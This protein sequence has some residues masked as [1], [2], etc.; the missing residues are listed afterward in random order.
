MLQRAFEIVR[1]LGNH[2][3]PEITGIKLG[4]LLENLLDAR[5]DS[6]NLR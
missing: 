6:E 4:V 1:Q 2:A 5:F 3:E